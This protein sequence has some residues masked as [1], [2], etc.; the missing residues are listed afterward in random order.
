[1]EE[2]MRLT[3]KCLGFG[4]GAF[5]ALVGWQHS[6]QAVLLSDLIANNGTIQDGDKLFSNFS[7]SVVSSTGNTFADPSQ[8]NVTS[9]AGPSVGITIG[10]GMSAQGGGS[11]LDVLFGY[12]VTVLDPTQKISELSLGFNGNAIGLPEDGQVGVSITETAFSGST[13]VGNIGVSAPLDLQ[14]PPYELFDIP[15]NGLHS[16]LDI[17]K[18]I[19]ISVAKGAAGSTGGTISLINQDYGQTQQVPEPAVLAL[20]GTGLVGAGLLRRRR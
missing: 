20:I 14:D 6:A 17:V 12:T 4:L 10:G 19:Q 8:L 3:A 16:S 18:D 1:M 15:L 7:F 5:V 11:F 2:R 13:I 9:L